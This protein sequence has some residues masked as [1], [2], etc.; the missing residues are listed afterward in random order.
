[1][2]RLIQR[3]CSLHLGG[4]IWFSEGS[5]CSQTSYSAHLA[6]GKSVFHATKRVDGCTRF[7]THHSWRL[8]PPEWCPVSL[9]KN[10]YRSAIKSPIR[11]TNLFDFPVMLPTYRITAFSSG[12]PSQDLHVTTYTPGFSGGHGRSDSRHF[13]R[14]APIVNGPVHGMIN[15]TRMSSARIVLDIAKPDNRHPLMG[16]AESSGTSNITATTSGSDTYPRPRSGLRA[17]QSGVQSGHHRRMK[18]GNA[19]LPALSSPAIPRDAWD[20]K[21]STIGASPA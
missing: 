20:T 18:T 16:S 5:S 9:P 14:S 1:M 6:H 15:P 12:S 10:P 3:P 8:R 17:S 7:V 11:V 2:L 21:I 4:L 13:S 19:P